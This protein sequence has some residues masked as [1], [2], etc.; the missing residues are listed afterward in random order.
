MCA[1][2]SSAGIVRPANLNAP[3]QVAISGEI[4]AVPYGRVAGTFGAHDVAPV[5]IGPTLYRLEITDEE[6]ADRSNVFDIDL[7]A[8]RLASAAASPASAS[9]ISNSW[10]PTRSAVVTG[11]A[12]GYH[13][14]SG[15]SWS[16]LT[17]P[18]T[19]GTSA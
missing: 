1:E 3:G 17:L 4:A 9:T 19:P 10:D 7:L 2:A 8:R 5:M 14:W 12:A 11:G 18:A 6:A 13:A 16:P 15:T